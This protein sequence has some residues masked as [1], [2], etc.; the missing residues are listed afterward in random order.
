MVRLL[1]S[2]SAQ[3]DAEECCATV[4]LKCNAQAVA[5][6]TEGDPAGD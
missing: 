5:A 3:Q 4:T 2:I 1:H 6:V